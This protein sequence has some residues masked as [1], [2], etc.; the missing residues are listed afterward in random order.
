M[1]RRIDWPR[2]ALVLWPDSLPDLPSCITLDGVADAEA[3]GAVV[4]A[5]EDDI[6]S[7]PIPSTRAMDAHLPQEEEDGA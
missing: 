1:P 7:E 5:R 4:I 6:M 3:R 2:F